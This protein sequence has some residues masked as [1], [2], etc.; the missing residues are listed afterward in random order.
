MSQA[1]IIGRFDGEYAFLS[2]F[3]RAEVLWDGL[4][5]P[6]TENFYQ[7]MKAEDPQNRALYQRMSAGQAKRSGKELPIRPDWEAVR[8]GVMAEALRQKFAPGTLLGFQ[9]LETGKAGL[10]EGNHWRDCFWG[11]DPN[12]NDGFGHN[13]LGT[14]LMRTRKW[15]RAGGDEAHWEATVIA[16]EFARFTL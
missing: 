11:V 13:W 12:Y 3:S 9:L 6:S 16:G 14:L 15:L 8:L 1:G 5:Y 2:N 4:R 10:V 7:A